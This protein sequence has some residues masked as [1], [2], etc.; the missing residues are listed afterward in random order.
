MGPRHAGRGIDR[1]FI[2]YKAAVNASMGPRLA[3]R[4]IAGNAA[5]YN[6]STNSFNG[7]T[8]RGP[9]YRCSSAPNVDKFTGFNGSTARA[10]WYRILPRYETLPLNE[11]QWVHGT[12]AVVSGGPDRNQ[13]RQRSRFNGSTA[14]SPWYRGDLQF[15]V[16]NRQ[17]FNG[18]TARSPWYRSCPS[19]GGCE[20]VAASMGPRLARRGIATPGAGLHARH[21]RFNGSTA[22]SPWYRSISLAVSSTITR[23]QWVHG[24]LAVV[25]MDFKAAVNRWMDASMGPR[26][27]RR[28]IGYGDRRT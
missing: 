18:S 19:D 12:L 20:G 25:S 14:R 11:L 22:R 26:L 7:S 27:A 28:G 1:L 10:P 4:G 15:V 5:P 16:A 21:H 6:V 24:S 13:G 17:G 8:A 2:S 9:W 3:R 23:L